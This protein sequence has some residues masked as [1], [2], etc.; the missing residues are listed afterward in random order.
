MILGYPRS[1]LV[2]L[3]EAL[4]ILDISLG[5]GRVASLGHQETRLRWRSCDIQRLTGLNLPRIRDSEVATFRIVA[6]FK[7]LSLESSW[8]VCAI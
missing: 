4:L 7:Y 8:Y 1:A 2:I 3:G 5:R 6:L